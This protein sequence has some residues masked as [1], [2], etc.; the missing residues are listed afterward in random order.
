MG[1][2]M[3]HICNDLEETGMFSMEEY[4]ALRQNS[5]SEFIAT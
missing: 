1:G 5:I 2:I 4:I 3:E